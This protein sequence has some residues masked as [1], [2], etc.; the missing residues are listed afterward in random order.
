MGLL[1]RFKN[2]KEIELKQGA[3]PVVSARALP[4]LDKSEGESKKETKE[5]PVKL[6]RHETT[7][8]ILAPVVTEKAAHLTE[9]GTYVFRV[10]YRATRI[11]VASAFKELYGVQPTKVNIVVAR[12]KKVR[13]GRSL[14]RE[15]AWKKAYVQ[16]PAGKQIQVYEAV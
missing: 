3:A 8:V 12:A 15:K 14:G 16:V 13:F 1:D 4:K 10:A 7:Q 11:Q 9:K 5:K 2:K 6:V